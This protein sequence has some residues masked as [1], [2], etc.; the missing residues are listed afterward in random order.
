MID[1][2]FLYP[3]HPI[4]PRPLGG[5]YLNDSWAPPRPR[6]DPPTQKF[7]PDLDLTSEIGLPSSDGR[8][9]GCPGPGPVSI[10]ARYSAANEICG[11]FFFYKI[12]LLGGLI[13][14]QLQFSAPLFFFP[15]R[16][17]LRAPNFQS[18]VS[19]ASAVHTCHPILLFSPT[20]TLR[21]SVAHLL[22]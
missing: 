18:Y 19:A 2:H 13:F 6:V 17:N 8:A 10:R 7:P 14:C 12:F 5:L 11:L 20:H 21:A 1:D 22:T 3:S 16:A 4:H 15:Q 9:G